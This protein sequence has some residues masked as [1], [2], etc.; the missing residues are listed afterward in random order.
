MLKHFV[1]A[2][3][4]LVFSV[5]VASAQGWE[6]VIEGTGQD[7][8]ADMVRT[9]DGGF[10]LAGYYNRTSNIRLIQTDDRGNIRWDKRYFPGVTAA[11]N[12]VTL[13]RDTGIVAVGYATSSTT[14]RDFHIFKT[15]R[16]GDLLWSVTP[17][18]LQ[19]E[20]LLDVMETP[21]GDLVVTGYK[22]DAAG[23]RD[24]YAAKYNASGTLLWERTFVSANQMTEEK[25][26]A[27]TILP[28]G[29]I[30]LAGERE[31]NSN[32]DVLMMRIDGSGNVVWEKIYDVSPGQSDRARAV[33]QTADGHLVVAGDATEGAYTVGLLMKLDQNGTNSPIWKRTFASVDLYDVSLS[34]SGGLFATGTTSLNGLDN[35]YILHADADGIKIWDRSVG[36][37]GPDQG[38]AV[39]PTADGGCAAAGVSDPSAAATGYSSYLVKTD[40][41]GVVF[42][43]WIAA[44]IYHDVNG[45]CQQDN[46]ER[47]LENWVVR[48]QRKKDNSVLYAVSRSDGSFRLPVDTSSYDFKVFSLQNYWESCLPTITVNVNSFYKDFPVD[49]PLRSLHSCPRNE[50]DVATP[51]LR[52][53]KDNV[54][55]VRY[56]NSGTAPSTDTRIEVTLD[57]DLRITDSD[58]PATN[59]GNGRYA[60]EVGTLNNG[61]CGSFN[62]TA[63]LDCADE[64]EGQ[65]HCVE[66][67][68]Y[69][70]DFC[71]VAAGWD[72][73]IIAAKARCVNGRVILSLINQGTQDMGSTL[74]YVIAED[75]IMLT[76][77]GDPLNQF[78]L[79]SGE[80]A[81]MLDTVANGKTYR[82][83]AEQSP[84]YPGF[85]NPTAAVEGCVGDTTTTVSL[86][87]YT[88]FPEDDEAP[89]IQRDCQESNKTDYAPVILKRGHPKGF[90]VPNYVYPNT[91]LEYLIQFRNTGTDTVEQVVVRDTL[92]VSLDPSTV[93]PGAASH[94][95]DFDVLGNG[96]VQFTLS[97]LELLPGNG[98]A[99]EGFVKFRV[100][101]RTDLPCK[102]DILNR[103]AVT[104]DFNKPQITNGVRY[105]AGCPL[106]SP[107]VTVYVDR[108][109]WPHAQLKAYP[110][111]FRESVVFEI[112]NVN[113]QQYSLELYDIQGR[114]ISTSSFNQPVYRLHA[115]QIP[116]GI[117]FYRLTADGKPVA[118]GKLIAA[119]P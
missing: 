117:V 30:I 99:S 112:Q 31:R 86:G 15:D 96:V 3:L 78:R 46:G 93:Y 22:E 65:T 62:F 87:F 113:A 5:G 73:V 110:N 80:E 94:P 1:F 109:A 16:F 72:S 10:L 102:T 33:V 11:A 49:I 116:T 9:K 118:S 53:C 88:M 85:S 100:K 55:R 44:K 91:D 52:R 64:L 75:V 66:A 20:E 50:I 81:T 61:D 14:N 105:T 43:S 45:N 71:G 41:D 18:R 37:P 74:E 6:R 40:R 32:F 90:D 25:G 77:P 59:L 68:I 48:V 101:A 111:P 76:A 98:S 119:G 82:I 17:K 103:A 108:V 63:Y 54:W 7:E 36:R 8:T 13:T 38:Y 23:L 84:G 95:Y 70:D 21:A 107:Y 79:K 92:P 106:D 51:V 69:P 39:V 58:R 56:C 89:G 29:D 115:H 2:L 34:N 24:L 26:Y 12:A 104:F 60:F 47:P 97:N 28:N 83:T 35:L 27:L 19:G 67:R 114:S 57:P 42:T 4:C